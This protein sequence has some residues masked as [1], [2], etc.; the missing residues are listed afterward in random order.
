MVL[1]DTSVW[2]DFFNGVENQQSL[3]LLQLLGQGEEDVFYTGLVLQEVLQ[4]IRKKSQRQSIRRD[5]E[6]F[7]FIEPSQE[8]HV[9]AAEVF[10]NCRGKGITVRKSVD[11]VLASLAMEYDLEILHRDKDFDYIAKVY[12]LRV[13]ECG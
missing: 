7:I 10:T 8:T 12:P 2:A 1:V 11:C 6:D 13:F 4:G 9:E 5:F 3:S